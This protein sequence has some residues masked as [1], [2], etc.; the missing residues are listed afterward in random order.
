M[1]IRRKVYSVALDENGEERYFST[2]E[3]VNEEDY[4]NEKLYASEQVEDEL[5]DELDYAKYAKRRE[6]SLAR[7]YGKVA[8]FK[9]DRR[10]SN[11]DIRYR[12]YLET[13]EMPKNF[14][15]RNIAK[16]AV[17][18][19]LTG[20]SLGGYLG[21][22]GGAKGA[23]IG[24]TLGLA[25]GAGLGAYAG[26]R[27]NKADEKRVRKVK[28]NGVY[29]ADEAYLKY[30]A[31]EIGK[32]KLKKAIKEDYKKKKQAEDNYGSMSSWD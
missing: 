27:L 23:A 21:A 6:K 32:D 15:K 8:K 13:G 11:D 12:K 10:A 26:H 20:G 16:G 19:G 17:A 7:K 25:A 1:Y 18:G 14:K 2:N 30:K 3:I 24:S 4:L 31:G 9:D 5:E 28:N 29:K 22:A